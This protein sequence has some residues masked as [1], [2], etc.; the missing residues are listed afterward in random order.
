MPPATRGAEEV[1]CRTGD[2]WSVNEEI[3]AGALLEADLAAPAAPAGALK[4]GSRK[5]EAL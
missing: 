1:A 4:S 3:A 5:P 2:T